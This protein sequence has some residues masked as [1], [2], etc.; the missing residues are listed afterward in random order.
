MRA[1]GRPDRGAALK[2]NAPPPLTGF[3]GGLQLH[4]PPYGR[5][6]P[7]RPAT[8]TPASKNDGPRRTSRC[9]RGHVT[10]SGS[11]P[12]T[13]THRPP[14]P[15][16]HSSAAALLPQACGTAPKGALMAIAFGSIARPGVCVLR[17]NE[18]FMD[19]EI[20][21][22]DSGGTGKVRRSSDGLPIWR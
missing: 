17:G 15:P 2:I 14:T 16:I 3:A 9:R 4:R 22:G 6:A 21:A 11:A 1:R 20:A 8:P 5:P 12:P 13:R 7:P 10:A 18:P 19:E